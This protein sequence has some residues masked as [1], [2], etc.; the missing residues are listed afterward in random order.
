MG[1]RRFL[2][3]N[4]PWHRNKG[5]FYGNVETRPSPRALSGS[6][7]LSQLEGFVNKFGKTQKKSKEKDCPWEKNYNFFE[8]KYW[9]TNTLHHNHDVMHIGKKYVAMCLEL[10]LTFLE[11]P[12][13]ISMRVLIYKTWVLGKSFPQSNRKTVGMCCYLRLSFQ[14]HLKRDIFCDVIEGA[15]FPDGSASNISR[16]VYPKERNFRL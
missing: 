14:C 16:L 11:R 3:E 8:L 5:L 9:N 4:H 13:I 15:N 2:K 10:Y 12:R 7:I 6:Q 1:H